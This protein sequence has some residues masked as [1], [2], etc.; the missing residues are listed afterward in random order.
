MVHLIDDTELVDAGMR[1]IT[2]FFKARLSRE[3]AAVSGVVD[4]V[5]MADDVGQQHGP[6][7]SPALYRERIQPFHRE[8]CDHARS[9]LPDALIEYHTDG[10]AFRLIPDLMAAGVQILEAVQ[11]ECAEMDPENLINHFG[12][13]L[14]FQ[15]GISVQ[16]VLPSATPEAVKVECRRLVDTLGRHGAYLAA[17]SHAIQ[18]GTPPENILAMLEAV[19]GPERYDAALEGARVVSA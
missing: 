6:L 17:P 3:V 9:Q 12:G 10:S 2:D 14:G 19:L 8:I 18:A 4:L 5:F 1:R 11:V 16:Q 7:L 13:R 15:G